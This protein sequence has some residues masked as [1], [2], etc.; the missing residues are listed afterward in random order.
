MTRV[1]TFGEIM[2]RLSPPGQERLF[3]TPALRTYF[4]G[5]EAN[6]A[7]TLAHFGLHSEYVTRLPANA[8]GDA[9]AGALR[10]E[11][12]DTG[13]CSRGGHRLGIFF[14]EP[15]ADLR[16][17]HVV[18]D[19]ANSA[20]SQISAADVDWPSALRGAAWFHVS[21][22]TPALGDGPAECVRTAITAA[23]SAGV[24]VSMDLNFRPAL[25][26]G[27][28][29]K[30]VMIPLAKSCDL[31]IGNPGALQAMLGIDGA[32]TVDASRAA[33]ERV[34]GEFGC[35]RVAL[36]HRDVRSA[37]EHGW[38]AALFEADGAQ[39][40]SSRQYDL[41][42]VDRVGGGD[43]FAGGL[44]YALLAGRPGDAALQFATAAGALK[45]SVPGDFN[46]VKVEEV[47]RLLAT[48]DTR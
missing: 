2:L 14:V 18:Y 30:P 46:R 20:F 8:I 43:A 44:I 28:D 48:V 42:V 11:G 12:V 35:R 5:S 32:G 45:L 24:P 39:L 9:A 41:R 13:R 40:H 34:H 47:D 26:A 21:G 37:S 23:R 3:Q 36:T 17:L 33:G 6:V 29:P 15:G 7:V 38:R 22:I 27:R 16:P 10:A 25:W 1:V 31:L 4:G 19:R